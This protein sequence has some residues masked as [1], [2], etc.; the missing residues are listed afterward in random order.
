MDMLGID[1]QYGENG[2]R[3]KLIDKLYDGGVVLFDGNLNPI[4]QGL[5]PEL[6][7]L[8]KKRIYNG[9]EKQNEKLKRNLIENAH[10]F[11][12]GELPDKFVKLW[13]I[14]D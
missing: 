13:K 6:K 11:I 14:V 8:S 12:N 2:G 10:L 5:D 1:S 7:K 9:N 4:F 3:G